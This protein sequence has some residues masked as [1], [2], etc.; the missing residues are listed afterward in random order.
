MTREQRNKH[1]EKELRDYWDGNNDTPLNE[2][3]VK[4]TKRLKEWEND[5]EPIIDESEYPKTRKLT[6]P[7]TGDIAICWGNK[8]HN[9]DGPALFPKGDKKQGEY[10]LYGIRYEMEEWKEMKKQWEGLP[11]YKTPAILMD[12]GSARN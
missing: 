4:F 12:A 10:Y 9:W 6:N 11:W 8:F 3:M 1:F 7:K 5:Y 2:A